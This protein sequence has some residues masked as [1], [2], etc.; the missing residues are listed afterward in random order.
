[1]NMAVPLR[2]TAMFIKPTGIRHKTFKA[3]TTIRGR[4]IEK[5]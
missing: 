5:K 4:E 3:A 1:M 2:G